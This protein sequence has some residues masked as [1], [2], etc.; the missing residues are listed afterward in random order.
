MNVLGVNCRITVSRPNLT[1]GKNPQSQTHLVVHVYCRT[2][3]DLV[4]LSTLNRDSIEQ[5]IREEAGIKVQF[6]WSLEIARKSR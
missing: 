4:K 3:E 2:E 6:R 5:A 1:Y